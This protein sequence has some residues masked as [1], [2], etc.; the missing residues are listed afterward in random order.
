V[1]RGAL[2]AVARN[3][4]LGGILSRAPIAREV[5]KRVV[6]GDSVEVAIGV[7]MNLADH[8]FHVSLERAAPSVTTAQEADEV[9]AEYRQLIETVAGAGLAG[10]GEVTVFAESLGT[11]EPAELEHARARLQDIVGHAAEHKVPVMLGMGPAVDAA[12]TL[13]WADGLQADG[14]DVGVTVPSV[15]RRSEGDCARLADRR[16]RLVKGGHRADTGIAYGQPIEVDKSYV[17][18]AKLLLAG[19]GEPS[20]ATHDPRL[21][22]IVE[23]LVDR[24]GRSQHSY[25]FAFFMGRQEGEQERLLEQ[26]ERV[27]VYVPYGPQWFERLVGGLAE[28]SSTVA[29][30]LRS[31][32]PGSP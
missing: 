29:A 7:A 28:Q 24:I 6:G 20:F 18:C 31:L 15:L 27:R 3:E 5:V 14:F 16:V 4:S 30:A 9:A 1:I 21:I 8:G 19:P 11:F 13:G 22:E 32:L 2:A 17:R 10:V 23:S 26:G 25:E 12:M